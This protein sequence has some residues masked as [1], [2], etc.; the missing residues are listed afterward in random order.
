MLQ[1][2]THTEELK[3]TEAL[4]VLVAVVVKMK[5]NGEL[6]SEVLD[7]LIPPSVE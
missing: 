6:V 4:V 2:Q 7:V 1:G 3:E 5:N